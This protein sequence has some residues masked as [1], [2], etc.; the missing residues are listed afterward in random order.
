MRAEVEKWGNSAIVRIP[1]PFLEE[2]HLNINAPV[3][4]RVEQGHL[5]VEPL[6]H[7]HFEHKQLIDAI[8][9][10]NCHD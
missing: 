2:C 9:P 8:T 7:P 6:Y 3:E 5:V 4:V 1:K 10:E